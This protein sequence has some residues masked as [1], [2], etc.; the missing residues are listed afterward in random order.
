MDIDYITIP[1]SDL[2]LAQTVCASISDTNKRNRAVANVLG[3]KVASRFFDGSYNIDSE[4]GLHNIA[5][6]LED[7]EISDIYI[8]NSYIDVRVYFTEDELSVPKSHFDLDI[9]PALY[10]FI[11]IKPDLSEGIVTGFIKPEDVNKENLKQDYYY[12]EENSLTSFYNVETHLKT[13]LDTF[14]I[15]S[16]LMYEYLEGSLEEDAKNSVIR[17]LIKSKSSRIKLAKIVKAQSAFN[18]VLLS[19]SDIQESEDEQEE[20]T[21]LEEPDLDNLFVPEVKEETEEKTEEEELLEAL[22]YT[23]EVTPS[24]AD[25]I[26]E[27]DKSLEE[28]EAS[29]SGQNEENIDTLFTGEQTG[30][31][32]K[33]KKSSGGFVFLLLFC[34]LAGCGYYA[35]TNYLAKPS[36]DNFGQN[37][38]PEMAEE[39]PIE[40]NIEPVVQ[41]EAMPVETVETMPAG[42]NKKEEAV[43]VAIPAIE[44][45]LDASVLVSNLRV[46]WEI[47]AGYANNASAKRYLFKLGKVIQLNLK[48]ELLLLTRPPLSNR[49]TVELKYEPNISKF[50]LVGIKDSSGEKMVDDV[51]LDTV[52]SALSMHISSN[53]DSFGK[54]QGNPVL[55]IRL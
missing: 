45:H 26:E 40:E 49:I 13:V 8:N 24:G 48:S 54:L 21:V 11:K 53:T 51:I 47:P 10:M 3:A 4:T 28:N 17:E 35:Y 33:K 34:V 7:V 44:K 14:S 12:I 15:P 52:K 6:V 31:P 38:L 2:E 25:I 18:L 22:D 41:Q 36:E 16:E 46:E 29:S 19:D 32:V 39:A 30:V 1:E 5:K 43:S 9:L 50:E 20:T 27:V 23:T 42:K 55:I 37:S